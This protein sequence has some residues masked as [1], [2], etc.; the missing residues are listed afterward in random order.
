MVNVKV[1][2]CIL[3]LHPIRLDVRV[4]TQR[5]EYRLVEIVAVVREAL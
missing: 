2:R 1:D 3:N 4:D 5:Q